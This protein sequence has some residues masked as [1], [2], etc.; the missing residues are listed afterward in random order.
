M[1][2]DN[3]NRGRFV[4]AGSGEAEWMEEWETSETD[5]RAPGCGGGSLLER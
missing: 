1:E 3:H 5:V 4:E 2:K